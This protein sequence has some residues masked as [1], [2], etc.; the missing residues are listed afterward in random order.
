MAERVRLGGSAGADIFVAKS[1]TI[2]PF[3]T[4]E[5]IWLLF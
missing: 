1:G 2:W 3:Q 5:R 4:L